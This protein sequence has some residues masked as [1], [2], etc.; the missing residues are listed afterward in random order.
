[1]T[2]TMDSE[3]KE[4]IKQEKHIKNSIMYPVYSKLCHIEEVYNLLQKGMVSEKEYEIAKK[5]TFKEISEE[6]SMSSSCL[7]KAHTLLE[8]NALS[9][10]EFA[11]LKKKLIT[12]SDTNKTTYKY[13]PKSLMGF[14]CHKKWLYYPLL[15]ILWCLNIILWLFHNLILKPILFCIDVRVIRSIFKI[16]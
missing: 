11:K 3:L 5:N 8:K 12:Q 15:I 9:E 13:K 7:E 1:M 16:K 14:I 2:E 6:K 4:L 10:A